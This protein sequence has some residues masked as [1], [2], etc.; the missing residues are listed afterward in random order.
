MDFEICRALLRGSY[1]L[2]ERTL[3]R[4]A[5]R[6]GDNVLEIGAGIG[7]VSL[8]CAKLAAPGQVT[9]YEANS[10]LAPL[11][12]ENFSLNGLTPHLISKAVTELGGQI[13][14]FKNEKFIASSIIEMNRISEKVTVESDSIDAA[15]SISK[16]NIIVMDVEGAEIG[17]LKKANLSS[18]REIIVEVHPHIVG[19]EPIHDMVLHLEQQGFVEKKRQRKTIWFSKT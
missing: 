9:S 14:F 7:I 5:I 15:I 17:L 12:R 4:A 6:T 13:H 1:E 18:I 2:A 16:A 11:M 8:V 3:A 19:H 10:T